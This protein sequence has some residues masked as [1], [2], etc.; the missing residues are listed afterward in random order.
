MNGK[1]MSQDENW[2]P[3]GF[4]EKGVG[5]GKAILCCTSTHRA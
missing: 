1:I 5:C 4:L 3:E 2:A